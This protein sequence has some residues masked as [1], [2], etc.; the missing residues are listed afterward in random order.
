MARSRLRRRDG[1]HRF[2]VFGRLRVRV[3]AHR[4][5]AELTALC[6]LS[7]SPASKP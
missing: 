2:V 6:P 1:H 4:A 7:K 5:A 3:A